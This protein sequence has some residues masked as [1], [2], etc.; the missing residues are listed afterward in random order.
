M[1]ARKVLDML[2]SNRIEELRLALE[3]ELYE[4]ALKAKPGAKKRYAA[5]KKYFNY[6]STSRECLQK[7]CRVQFEGKDYI[8]FCNSWSLVLTNEDHG[9]I[10]LFDEENGKYPD[11]C[12]LLRFDG[13]KKKIDFAKVIAEAKSKGYRLSKKEVESTFKYVMYYDGAYY[14]IGLI[15][16]TFGIIDDGEVAMTYHPAGERLPITIQNDLGICMIM[17][18]KYEGVSE[19]DGKIVI[20]V[21]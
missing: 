14:K 6:H 13:I 4:E 11:V 12:R 9:E 18:V 10:E 5:M 3:D 7:P 8:S 1:H 21:E 16:A 19:E 20:E 17:P 15:D 2:D